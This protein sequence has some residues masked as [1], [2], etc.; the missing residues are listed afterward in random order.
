VFNNDPPLWNVTA[1]EER[2][3]R[4]RDVFKATNGSGEPYTNPFSPVEK[5]ASE[6]EAGTFPIFKSAPMGKAWRWGV[7]LTGIVLTALFVALC[8]GLG[9][10]WRYLKQAVESGAY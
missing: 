1:I 6:S 7:L 9:Q 3:N 8:M 2:L 5:P 4:T 10:Y